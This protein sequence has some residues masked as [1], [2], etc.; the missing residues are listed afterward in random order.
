MI[1]LRLEGHI[2]VEAVLDEGS[3]VIGLR[4]DIWKKLGL[5]ILPKQT[6]VMQSENKFCNTTMGLLP[7]LRVTIGN[8]DFYLWVQVIDNTSYEMLLG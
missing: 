4:H 1:P 5:P 6:M 2:S 8:C 3:Q 7:N